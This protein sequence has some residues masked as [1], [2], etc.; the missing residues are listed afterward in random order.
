MTGLRQGNKQRYLVAAGLTDAMLAAPQTAGTMHKAAVIALGRRHR[1]LRPLIGRICKQ[2][3][4]ALEMATRRKLI[5]FILADAR[6]DAAFNRESWPNIAS[7]PLAGH[8]GRACPTALSVLSLPSLRDAA[9][10]AQWLSLTPGELAWFAD[11]HGINRAAAGALCHYHCRW[12]PKRSGGRRLIE[13]PKPRLHAM[14]RKILHEILDLVPPHG[15]AHGFRRGRSCKTFVDSHVSQSVVVRLDLD[16]F[17]GSIAVSRVAA[18]FRRLGYPERAAEALAGLCTLRTPHGILTTKRVTW[19]ERDRL[20]APHLPQGAPTSPALANLCAFGLDC[21]L[22][23]LAKK[24]GGN[25]S[26]YADDLAISGGEAVRR[27]ANALVTRMSAIVIEE[28]FSVNFRKTKIMYQSE[29]QILT[30]IIVNEKANVP[31]ADYDRLKAIIHNGLR[32]GAL[33]QNIAGHH[34]FRAHLL[35][36]VQHVASLNAARGAKLMRLYHQLDWSAD[37]QA[38]PT[39]HKLEFSSTSSGVD[40]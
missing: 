38:S 19:Q 25:Y 39:M 40:G 12:V 27:G 11:P 16:N 15:A 9:S 30:G 21:R 6:F 35:G 23:A 3:G 7:Y 33:A 8:A 37:H 32:D 2:Y 20:R 17:F 36:R 14:Q 18:L 5:Q 10:V 22:E 26:R 29:R 34:D 4:D 24:I 1:W 13:E 28:G 31:R